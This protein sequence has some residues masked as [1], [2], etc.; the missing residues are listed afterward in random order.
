M[1]DGG[2]CFRAAIR[3]LCLPERS[4]GPEAKLATNPLDLAIDL[5]RVEFELR[6]L[7]AEME[8]LSSDERKVEFRSRLHALLERQKALADAVHD[9]AD[10]DTGKLPDESLAPK[11]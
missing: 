4:D 5:L 1:R 7:Q 9:F 11:S 8:R 6:N 10:Q 2:R 3:L